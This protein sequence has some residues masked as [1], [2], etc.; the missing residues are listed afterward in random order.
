MKK[1]LLRSFS[2][3]LAT[4]SI[5]VAQNKNGKISNF[6]GDNTVAR[7]NHPIAAGID[8]LGISFLDKVNQ[9]NQNQAL[10]IQMVG[11]T[12][13]Q[14]IYDL[15]TNASIGNRASRNADGTGH[16]NYTFTPIT[17][18]NATDRGTGYNYYNGT[19]WSAAPSARIENVRVGF[20]DYAIL[21]NNKELVVA[22][23]AGNGVGGNGSLQL[24]TRPSKGT[25]PWTTTSISSN[26]EAGY[27]N[28]ALTWARIAAGGANG[29]TVHIICNTYSAA[30][31]PTAATFPKVNGVPSFL[32]YLRSTDGGVTF[33]K[34]AMPTLD[35]ANFRGGRIS[36]EAYSIDCKGD[37]V[38]VVV[39]K[40]GADIQLAKSVDGGITW[41]KTKIY[42]APNI[43]T[44]A[45]GTTAPD[46][47]DGSDG[48][49]NVLIDKD[50]KVHAFWGLFRAF[51]PDTASGFS[52]FP[53]ASAIGHWTEGQPLGSKTVPNSY[54]AGIP[55]LNGNGLLDLL[56]SGNDRQ[57]IFGEIGNT[58]W[59]SFP[60]AGYDANNN[61]VLSYSSVV[62]D[63]S[64]LDP[65]T[66]V[67]YPG[68][69][70]ISIGS[71][72]RH[73]RHMYLIKGTKVPN[74]N[75]AQWCFTN[76][77]L[78]L[79]IVDP[80]RVLPIE[81]MFGGISRRNNSTDV[82]TYWQQDEAAGSVITG[83]NNPNGV[84][85]LTEY[86]DNNSVVSIEL[87]GDI[88]PLASI[89]TTS[90]SCDTIA[91]S[92]TN[93][94]LRVNDFAKLYP[95]PSNGQLNIYLS[96]IVKSAA[97]VEIINL[98]GQTVYTAKVNIGY[99]KFNVTNLN[100]G[101]YFAVISI[102]GAKST[103]KLVIE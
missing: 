94:K 65:G 33:T 29:Q 57:N 81:G 99:N 91:S 51:D 79:D 9:S 103:Q 84:Q 14:T 42:T 98:L 45:V 10:R 26:T 63:T 4:A 23:G 60:Y 3:L 18:A 20:G 54:I 62:E 70:A 90:G 39:C 41:T 88:I 53:N 11:V 28:V 71:K 15:Q 40:L 80:L 36:A 77:D 16:A 55:D 38:A 56:P 58:G 69:P 37:T 17:G 48:S 34:Q 32:V 27:T 13:A 44:G 64:Y 12:L 66:V 92:I 30:A 50:N 76:S 31:A 25:G 97:N 89:N 46:T 59:A 102:D 52:F 6:I 86:F 24:S 61:I 47:V 85:N 93:G 67:A 5:G 101:T 72:R 49:V 95:N 1:Q 8:P 2:L 83:G 78:A 87:K 75:P 82:L 7:I 96:S 68:P 100:A 74:S 43:V 35:T 73:L 19:S 21:P 22:H